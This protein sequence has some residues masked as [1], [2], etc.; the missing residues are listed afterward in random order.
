MAYKPLVLSGYKPVNAP[1]I[2]EL[3]LNYMGRIFQLVFKKISRQ[4]LPG[5]ISDS[6]QQKAATK[7]QT[8]T[9]QRTLAYRKESA[10]F[11]HY[12]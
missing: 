11:R 5:K 3:N 4:V 8:K 12:K 7:K 10:G 2:S 9:T 6:P 1:N